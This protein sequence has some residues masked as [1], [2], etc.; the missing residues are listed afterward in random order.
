M[1]EYY[2]GMQKRGGAGIRSG[3]KRALPAKSKLQVATRKV[4]NFKSGKSKMNATVDNF[5]VVDQITSK[6][7]S[8]QHLNS[9]PNV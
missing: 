8:A 7:E 2:F 9:R 3:K 5:T 4:A 6:W 1:N